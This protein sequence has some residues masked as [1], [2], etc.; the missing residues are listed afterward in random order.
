M[1]E[2]ARLLQD[3]I[4]LSHELA[5]EER[6]LAILGEGNTS[7]DCGDGTFWIKASGSQLS[8]IDASGF[9]RVRIQPVLDLVDGGPLSDMQIAAGIRDALVD[10]TS[11]QPSVETFLHALCLREGGARWVG[12]THPIS[13]NRFLCSQLGAQPFLRHLFPDAIVVCGAAPAIVNYVDPGLPLAKAVRDELHRYQD[14]HGRSPKVL[15][16]L[17][18]GLVALGQS[19]R[20]VLNISLMADKWARILHGTY[21]LGGPHYLAD[22]HLERIDKRPDEHYRRRQLNE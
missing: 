12:H 21:A 17:N 7:A 9:S 11:R 6:Q 15:L 14:A 16:M 5:R 8:D 20:E 13:V 22:V 2:E 4:A 3:L 19:P 18:H 10:G 1:M